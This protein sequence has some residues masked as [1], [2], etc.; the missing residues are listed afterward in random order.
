MEESKRLKKLEYQRKW[1]KE[2]Y[3]KHI[4][5]AETAK[6]KKLAM[7]GTTYD[8]NYYQKAKDIYK[9]AN[10]K[11]VES[12][13]EHMQEY[14]RKYF[15]AHQEKMKESSRK[16]AD[17]LRAEG[18]FDTPEFKEKTH[19]YYLD[20][21]EKI[22]E[23]SRQYKKDNKDEVKTKR[24]NYYRKNH[25]EYLAYQKAYRERKKLEKSLDKSK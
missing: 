14:R 7:S 12:N 22:R 19:Q 1:M 17:R 4:I 20:N 21:R 25:D 23:K 2:N 9:E 10:K 5:H 16:R 18:Y 3:D 11:W 8:K 13:K 6:Q 24:K 15:E